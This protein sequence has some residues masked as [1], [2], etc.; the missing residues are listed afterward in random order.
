MSVGIVQK[1]ITDEQII[2]GVDD[3]L[4]EVDIPI[5]AEYAHK[6]GMSSQHICKRAKMSPAVDEAVNRIKEEKEIRIERG[7]L[8]GKMNASAGIFS[9]KQLGW[10]DKVE[11]DVKA[12]LS[13]NPLAEAIRSAAG[14]ARPKE[15]GFSGKVE[16]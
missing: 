13:I 9:L 2:N 14:G 8:T 12:D 15:G 16:Q 6:I 1:A 10:R 11:A 5:V 3:Y 7:V 4:N